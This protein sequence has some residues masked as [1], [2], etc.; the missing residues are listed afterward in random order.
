MWL[1]V[2]DCVYIVYIHTH[3]HVVYIYTHYLRAAA[4]AADPGRSGKE[5]KLAEKRFGALHLEV[6]DLFAM[7]ILVKYIW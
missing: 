5:A 6:L 2:Y 1:R 4:P 7:Y 3:I